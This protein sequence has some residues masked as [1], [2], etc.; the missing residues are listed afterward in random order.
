MLN[1]SLPLV[2]PVSAAVY[3]AVVHLLLLWAQ[4]SARLSRPRD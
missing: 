1:S 2:I 4:R 3:L